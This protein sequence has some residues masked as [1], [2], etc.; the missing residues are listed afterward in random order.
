MFTSERIKLAADILHST[1]TYRQ[2]LHKLSIKHK[3]TRINKL[4]FL[5]FRCVTHLVM[6]R[7]LEGDREEHYGTVNFW[8]CKQY[9]I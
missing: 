8:R 3:I 4:H 6:D 2:N 9:L 7:T 1:P 5:H